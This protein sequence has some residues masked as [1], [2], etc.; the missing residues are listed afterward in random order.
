MI[1]AGWRYFGPFVRKRGDLRVL[2]CLPTCN[3]I[4][5]VEV[6]FLPMFLDCPLVCRMLEGHRN[7]GEFLRVLAVVGLSAKE[8]SFEVYGSVFVWVKDLDT[9]LSC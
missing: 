1:F 9:V 8:T 3:R 4:A 6:L 2:P 5:S 7:D